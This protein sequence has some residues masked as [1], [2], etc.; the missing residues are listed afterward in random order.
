VLA[1]VASLALTCAVA[2]QS[3]PG[4]VIQSVPPPV[5]QNPK[6]PPL[7]LTDDQRARIRQALSGEDTEVSFALKNAKPSQGFAPSVGAKVPSGLH[8]LALPQPL[9]RQMP[10]LKRY[11]YLKFKGEVLIV[12]PMTRKIVDQFA[13][14]G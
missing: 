3:R 12:D 7:H 5:A 6:P 14:A 2:A 1:T 4:G 11:S 8:P 10:Q 9:V 13:E